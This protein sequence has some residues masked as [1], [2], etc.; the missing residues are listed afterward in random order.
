[1]STRFV[2]IALSSELDT[3]GTERVHAAPYSR[4]VRIPYDGGGPPDP[5][6]GVWWDPENTWWYAGG[7]PFQLIPEN[8]TDEG[9]TFNAYD[10]GVSDNT[11][12]YTR[13]VQAR[14]VGGTGLY[15][16]EIVP[17]TSIGAYSYYGAISDTAPAQIEPY[18][19]GVILI[20]SL[21]FSPHIFGQNFGKAITPDLVVGSVYGFL[22]N[23]AT[24]KVW[25]S[26]DGEWD[27]VE[28]SD[29]GGWE[30]ITL[31]AGGYRPFSQFN[32]DYGVDG[33]VLPG[34]A[35]RVY[36]EEL[37]YLPDGANAWSDGVLG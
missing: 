8:L 11:Y 16:F 3:T 1:M 20:D 5:V 2:P 25:V 24:G 31:P 33:A 21:L 35:L 7:D 29:A 26:I 12:S 28:P 22:F 27:D 34:A 14:S 17:E 15:Y 23:L 30:G 18:S 13:A 10:D 19:S 6:E 32:F 9:R 4:T 36:E 37:S